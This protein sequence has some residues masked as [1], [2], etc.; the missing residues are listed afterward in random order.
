VGVIRRLISDHFPKARS[1]LRALSRLR[2][3][4]KYRIL[5]RYGVSVRARPKLYLKYLLWDPE[6]ESY[7]FDISN[8]DELVRLLADVFGAPASALW[9]YLD[10]TDRDPEL[11]ELLS[12]RIRWRFDTKGRLPLGNRL[13]WYLAARHL[14][15]ALIV[16][17]GIY[18]GMGSL[19]LL[20]ALDQN[21]ADGHPGTLLS[22]DFDPEAG[23]LVPEHLRGRWERHVGLTQDVLER[24]VGDRT[25]GMLLQDTPHTEENQSLE[26]GV[27][28]RHAADPLLL[29]ESSGGYCP[30]LQRLCDALKIHRHFFREVP[31][32]HFYPPNGS[33]FA[34]ID[35]ATLEE[36][37]SAADE[38]L[39]TNTATRP[40]A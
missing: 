13:L 39:R 23:R 10:E 33:G 28:L 25:V 15:P 1:R 26:F 12:E 35:R 24:A 32:D 4:T 27:A 40:A 16:E 11:N 17:T 30:T 18:E 3:V 38:A 9:G 31:K 20:R 22:V 5:R 36:R 7:T 29:I 19:V 14:K 6:V 8:Q 2:W 34:L 37:Y 21:A